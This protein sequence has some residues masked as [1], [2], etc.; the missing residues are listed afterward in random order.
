MSTSLLQILQTFL[1][2]LGVLGAIWGIYDMFG[3]GQQSS[4]G[5]KKIIGGIAFAAISFFL[6]NY[7]IKNVTAAE[8]KAG[9]SACVLPALSLLSRL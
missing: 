8:A 4:I 1:V 2:V 9:I 7:A 5:I 6:L 3:E